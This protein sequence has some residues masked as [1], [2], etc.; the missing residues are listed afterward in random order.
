M[1]TT[2]PFKV[3]ASTL[4]GIIM[5]QWIKKHILILS[6]PPVILLFFGTLFDLR[7]VIVALMYIFVII[8]PIMMIVYFYHAMSPEAR[9]SLLPH[10]VSC[11]SEGLH[12]NYLPIDDTSL[13]RDPEI[14]SWP[15]ISSYK[16]SSTGITIFLSLST[17]SIIYIPYIVFDDKKKLHSMCNFIAKNLHS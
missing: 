10:T 1:I 17:Y 14:I 12:I 9:Y 8:P 11:D 4:T 16:I 15:K 6:L 5:R 3:E 13:P 2:E 7:L